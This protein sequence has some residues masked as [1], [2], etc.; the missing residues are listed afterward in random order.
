MKRN[1][2]SLGILLSLIT[3]G[4]TES[5]PV[6]SFTGWD[7]SLFT[8]TNGWIQVSEKQNTGTSSVDLF[9][10]KA[11]CVKDNIHSFSGDQY[12]ITEGGTRCQKTDSTI[13]ESG[14]WKLDN[15]VLTFAPNLG[16]PY[17]FTLQKLEKVGWEVV[18]VETGTN[19]SVS[20]T[21]TSRFV[22]AVPSAN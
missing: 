6:P 12:Q 11:A 3:I 16:D 19:G 17:S 15:G 1:A 13:V 2:F 14:T 8:N 10:S 20:R 4:C 18:V 7:A 21:T 22:V 5:D 9:E